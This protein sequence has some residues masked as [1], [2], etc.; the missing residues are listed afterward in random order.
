MSFYFMRDAILSE[1]YDTTF[2]PVH[3]QSFFRKIEID[4][5]LFTFIIKKTEAHNLRFA[6]SNLQC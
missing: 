3:Y 6:G 2:R 1:I 4:I 5:Y